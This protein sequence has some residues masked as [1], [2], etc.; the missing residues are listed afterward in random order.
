[1]KV[2]HLII[3][4]VLGLLLTAAAAHAQT[5]T[6]Q[7]A[8][9]TSDALAKVTTYTTTLQIGTGAVATVTPVCAAAGTGASC[10]VTGFTFNAAAA[11][12]FKVVLIDPATGQSATGTLNYAPGN[13]PA[14][15]TLTM[16]WQIKVP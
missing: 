12:T 5:V 9:N 14:S 2:R 13:P 15:F 6:P 16:Q 10:T 4:L 8:W 11:T 1:M 7:L 3:A